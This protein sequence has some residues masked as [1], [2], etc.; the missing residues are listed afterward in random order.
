LLNKGGNTNVE[1]VMSPIRRRIALIPFKP[2]PSTLIL[3]N[4]FPILILMGMIK[5]IVSHYTQNYG[6]KYNYKLLM[7]TKDMIPR[8]TIKGKVP[9]T[10]V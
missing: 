9:S 5:I 3:I 10:R 6:I 1:S 4:H 7:L 2:L 8:K